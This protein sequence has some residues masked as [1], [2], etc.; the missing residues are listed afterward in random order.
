MVKPTKALEIAAKVFDHVVGKSSSLQ[1]L[2]PAKIGVYFISSIRDGLFEVV[3][4]FEEGAEHDIW[5]LVKRPGPEDKKISVYVRF[6]C[7]ETTVFLPL[8]KDG[9]ILQPYSTSLRFR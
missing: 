9:N 8:D 6:D 2:T 4:V 7:W 1:G 5:I 3:A